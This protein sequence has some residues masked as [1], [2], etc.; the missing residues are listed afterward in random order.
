MPLLKVKGAAGSAVKI[1]PAE[2]I[3]PDG[4]VDRVSSGGAKSKSYWQY[5]LAGRDSEIWFPKYFYLGRPTGA[6]G[7]SRAGLARHSSSRVGSISSKRRR[8]SG[9]SDPRSLWLTM[10]TRNRSAM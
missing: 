3:A 10:P 6:A 9:G 2:L 8:K 4:S 1:I 7:T 5:T